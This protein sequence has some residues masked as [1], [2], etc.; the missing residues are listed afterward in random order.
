MIP[1]VPGKITARP[2]NVN[3]TRL[4][5]IGVVAIIVIGLLRAAFSHHETAYERIAREMT[6]AL[7]SNDLAAVDK[8]QNAETVT[9]VSHSVVGHAA[10]LF[11]PLGK[12]QR[13]RETSVTDRTHQFDATFDKAVVHET[14]RFDPDNKV[15]GFRYDQPAMK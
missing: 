5:L 14:I 6:V 10:D 11:A 12:L 7:Q 2:S 15:V 13:V 8:F 3:T 4:L 1:A 9:H